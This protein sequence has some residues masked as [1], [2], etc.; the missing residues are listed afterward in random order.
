VTH[1]RREEDGTIGTAVAG[2]GAS[3]SLD[4]PGLA[5]AVDVLFAGL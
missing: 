5:M 4:P 1:H 3:L 2:S